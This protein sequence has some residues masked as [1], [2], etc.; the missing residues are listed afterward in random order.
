MVITSRDNKIFKKAKSLSVREKRDENKMFLAEGSRAVCD[1][2]KKN[3]KLH[4]LLLREGT[5]PPFTPSCPVYT[6]SPRLFGEIS[7]TVTPQGIAAICSMREL[8]LED[9]RVN[10]NSAV[11]M[12]EDVQDP[13]NIGTIIRSAH[14]CFAGGV[15]LTKGCC[16]LYNPKIIRATMSSVF[17]VPVIR[18]V[19][20]QKAVSFFKKKGFKTVGGA[21]GKDSS[22]LYETDIKGKTLIIIGNEGN[23]IKKETLDMC[24][25]RVIIPMKSDAESLN[26]AVAASIM[27][28]EHARQNAKNFG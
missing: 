27:L 8:S 2:A 18:N 1:A 24:D 5:A 20:A 7:Q 15:V 21:L 12:C 10:E 17:S 6:F 11:I 25:K 14:A 3:V 22:V 26:A 28:Y 19:S 9:I 4:A 16:D 23:G 13:G